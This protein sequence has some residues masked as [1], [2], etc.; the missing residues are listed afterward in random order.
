MNTAVIYIVKSWIPKEYA[1]EFNAWYDSTHMPQVAK[2]SGCAKA[3]R[4]RAVQTDDKFMYMAVYEF[5]DM[6]AF[7]KYENSEAKKEL[8]A[9]FRK[10]YGGKA[11][12]KKYVWEQV[13]EA[14]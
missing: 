6:D 8:V 1:G 12:T 10:N 5:P 7:L 14:V 13:Y 4:F 2:A 9:D 3:R 11:E